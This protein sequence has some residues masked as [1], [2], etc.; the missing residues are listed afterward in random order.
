[1]FKP[2]DTS[3]SRGVSRVDA[4]DED[5]IRRAFEYA[6]GYSPSKAVCVEEYL[7][8]T[9]VGG[10][11]L[12]VDG[13]LA[14]AAITHKHKRGFVVTG[15]SLPTNISAD[16]QERV[17]REVEVNCAAT[18]YSDGALNF[19]VMVSPDRVTVLEMSPRHGGNGIPML[20]E[21]GTGVDILAATLRFA[22]G[23]DVVLAADPAVRKP[24]G[25]WVFGSD[26]AGIVEEIASEE[27]VRSAVPEVLTCS[28]HAQQGEQVPAFIHNGNSL[29]FVLFDCFP[30]AE[31]EQVVA[32]L[33]SALRLKVR[34]VEGKES[35]P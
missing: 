15:H 16:D 14:F 26:R 23:E 30:Q 24:C 17:C 27:M 1:M 2:V 25:S 22:V 8:G 20:I 29:G 34:A 10:D 35:S 13:R 19:D 33:Q 4:F 32:R 9:E 28:I 7:D 12:L 3:G 31:Y 5:Q 6:Q 11:G 21:H 18:G